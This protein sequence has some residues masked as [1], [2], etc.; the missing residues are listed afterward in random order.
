MTL[1]VIRYEQYG[2]MGCQVPKNEIQNKIA[3]AKDQHMLKGNYCTLSIKLV[4]YR[5]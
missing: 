2:H 4:T 1:I 5:L 3:F